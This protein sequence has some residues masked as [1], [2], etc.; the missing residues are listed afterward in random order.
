MSIRIVRA[1]KIDSTIEGN[2]YYSPISA[3]LN[4]EKVENYTFTDETSYVG[5]VLEYHTEEVRV[6]SDVWDTGVFAT[7]W[8]PENLGGKL[9]PENEF[10][11]RTQ[12]SSATKLCV[13]THFNDSAQYI[14][15][16]DAPQ[17]IIDAWKAETARIAKENQQKHYELLALERRARIEKGSIVTVIKGHKVTK[18]TTGKVL[19]LGDSG[20]GTQAMIATTNR[21][22]PKPGKNGKVFENSYLDVVYCSVS[23]LSVVG[24]ES[25]A[26]LIVAQWAFENDKEAID[27]VETVATAYF[28]PEA[29]RT[30][31]SPDLTNQEKLEALATVFAQ[32]F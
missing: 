6:M 25:E 4:S 30:L 26:G 19:W 14:V 8:N 9:Y 7:I 18:G 23:N 1:H 11:S 16:V 10:D 24:K 3:F 22:G 28:P 32:V 21:K 12:T 27:C 17:D 29:T 13:G 15:T 20:Y 5:M 31:E 2:S